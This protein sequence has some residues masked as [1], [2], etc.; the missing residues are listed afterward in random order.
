MPPLS[1]MPVNNSQN[2]SCEKQYTGKTYGQVVH[3]LFRSL[4]Q[5]T[6]AENGVPKQNPTVAFTKICFEAMLLK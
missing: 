4:G 2:F 6:S 5:T 3:L 1:S